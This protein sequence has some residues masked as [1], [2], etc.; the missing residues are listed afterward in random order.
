[1]L[2]NGKR[3]LKLIN[4][5]LDFSKLEAGRMNIKKTK[6]DI[7]EMLK[8]YRSAVHSGATAMGLNII[9]NDNT[10]GIAAYIDRDLMEKAVFNLISNA[11]KFSP[12]GGN[13]ILQLDKTS[14]DNFSISVKDEGIGIPSD[15]INTI[16]ERFS[17]VDGTSS[18]KYEGTG[19][20]LAFT[21]EIVELHSGTIS[22]RSKVNEGSV[23]TMTLPIGKPDE[24]TIE[25]EIDNIADVKDYLLADIGSDE[26]S[27]GEKFE[28]PSPHPFIKTGEGAAKAKGEGILG[29]GPRSADE[30][31]SREGIRYKLLVIDDTADMRKF[32][33]TLLK[34]EYQIITAVNGRD[35]FEKAKTER[36]DLIISDVMMPEMDGYELTRAI[37]SDNSLSGTP[38]IL[39]TAR[40]DVDMKIEGLE[41]GADDYLSKPFNSKELRARIK[42]QLKMKSL[43][44]TVEHQ[45]DGLKSEVDKQMKIILGSEKLRRY[46]P[47]PIIEPILRGEECR[48]LDAKAERKNLTIFFS[49]IVGFTA[50]TDRMESEKLTWLLN[51]YLSEMAKIVHYHGGTIDK[52]IG[53]AVMVHFGAFNSKGTRYP[54]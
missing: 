11:L 36:P 18:R 12:K 44:D 21:K 39:L 53:D 5:L 35:G 19:I 37:K 34:N 16:F 22:V 51:D 33:T 8:I 29:K 7:R 17:Q 10:D 42:S 45:R 40:A 46:L 27:V 50:K 28:H 4:N 14:D 25:D 20:G 54:A 32:I 41:F 23:F 9:F 30:G 52:F 24:N 13:I 15:K 48:I 2:G 3:L 1:M 38:V 49:D 47:A 6:T 31:I 26:S 43:R